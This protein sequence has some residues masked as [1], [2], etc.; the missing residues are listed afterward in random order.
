MERVQKQHILK[1]LDKKMVFV[2]GPRQAG[3]TWLAKEIAKHFE[4]SVYLNYDQIEHREIIK[5]K[6]GETQRI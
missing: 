5:I 4:H 2:A 3:K 6:N 1:D